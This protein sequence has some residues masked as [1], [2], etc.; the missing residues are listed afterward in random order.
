[1][2]SSPNN[3]F[4]EILDAVEK[5]T[6]DEAIEKYN[7]LADKNDPD[8]IPILIVGMSD[9][10]GDESDSESPNQDWLMGEPQ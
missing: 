4:H 9:F 8:V 2:P 5:N 3:L 6:S 10:L 1:M 7:E